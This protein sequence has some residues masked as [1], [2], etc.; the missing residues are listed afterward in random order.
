MDA[1]RYGEAIQL[2]N[3][4]I[5][6]N[7]DAADGY[8]LRGVCYEN[9]SQLNDAA[10]DLRRAAALKPSNSE[11]QRNLTRVEAAL[12]TAMEKKIEGHKRELARNPKAV[13]NYLEIARAYSDHERW[14]E[15]EQ[16]YDEY[17]QR[18]E[19]SPDDL[20]K[21][22]E[23]LAH[24]NQLAKGQKVLQRYTDRYSD[25]A[26]L[27]S[28]Y[29]YFLLWNGNYPG[30]T[31]AFEKALA[32]QPDLREARD[33][34]A[35]AKAKPRGPGEGTPRDVRTE[36]ANE[37]AIDKYYRSL[38]SNPRDDETRFRLVDELADKE[39]FAEALQQLDTLARGPADSIRILFA[40]Q[41]V[42]STQASVYQARIETYTERLRN[43]PSDKDA[44]LRI[45]SLHAELGDYPNA[46]LYL[47]L[48]LTDVPENEATDIRYRYA[49][50]AAWGKQFD[51]AL[52]GLNPLLAKDPNNIEYQLLRG[53][54]A[55]WSAS[56]LPAG[57]RYLTNVFRQNTNN[58]AAVLALS[59]VHALQG[60][61][62]D[63]YELLQRAKRIDPTN[64]EIRNVQALYDNAVAESQER[65]RFAILSEARQLTVEGA[66]ARAIKK[67]DEYFVKTPAP[68]RYALMEY[69]DAHSCAKS[70]DKAIDIYDRLL[71]REYDFDVAVLRAKNYLWRGEARKAL[72]EFTR[73]TAERPADFSARLFLGETYHTLQNLPEAR[74]IYQ[75][76]LDS[77]TD[78][79]ERKMVQEKMRYL[80]STGLMSALAAFPTHMAFAP[81][82]TYYSDNQ[83]FQMSNFGG[84]VELGI[85][86]FVSFGAS[87]VRTTV[88][89]SLADRTL[90]GFKGQ[91]FLRL[92]DAFSA[93]GAYGTLT[94]PGQPKRDI[95]DAA[96]RIEKPGSLSLIAQVERADAVQ[97][98]YSPYLVDLLYGA[99]YYRFSGSYQNKA[100]VI[101]SGTYKYITISDGNMMNEVQLRIGR[102]FFDEA[103]L[104]YE[105]VFTNFN[106]QAA[107]IPFSN[108][109]KQIYYS[110]QNLESHSLWIDWSAENADD[111]KVDLG[112]RLGY[113]PAYKAM[114]RE[115]YGDLRYRPLL[116]MSVS[117]RVT[118]GSTMRNDDSYNYV[119][120]ALSAY[121][122]FY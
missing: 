7:P 19:A 38:R 2:L 25:N 58:I 35:R 91:L 55:V 82:L 79:T 74:R 5:A 78:L 110:P 46:T 10:L 24:T 23:V 36:P 57:Q 115:I 14:K 70:F 12:R 73:L 87:L 63:A 59:S 111:L 77:T 43:D 1:G 31:K 121:V 29:G 42:V 16:W 92:S 101:F 33:G 95:Y 17:L 32:L 97:I 116:Y 45:A 53:Q 89:S 37:F 75:S 49:Q 83:S 117:G 99:T 50:Y 62:R 108:H 100:H 69:A 68:P 94:S 39:R 4:Y 81:P 64:G 21:Y 34:L 48:Y 18:T 27:W 80:P 28:R 47:E 109:A 114:T 60:N 96:L 102:R 76:L 107:Y 56:D 54:I 61:L 11:I 106:H 26:G 90:T 103:A 40:R 113:I 71:E 41:H 15:A 13:N 20:L 67:Y 30:A 3:K 9:R 105:Y 6:Q 118:L 84:R 88:R 120:F 66:C 72:E 93:E 85:V 104:G 44:A 112:G 98:L 119:S 8:N 52:A 51:K 65:E 22:C 86:R 122:S